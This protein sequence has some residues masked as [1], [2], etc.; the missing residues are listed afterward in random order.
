MRA[1]LLAARDPSNPHRAGGDITMWEVARHLA[2]RGDAVDYVCASFPGAAPE[3][4]REGVHIERLGGLFTAAPRAFLRYARGRRAR[5]DVVVEEALGGLRIPYV[6]SAYVGVPTV[7]FWYQT[8]RTIFE[9]QFGPRAAWGL[10]RVE[11]ML[12]RLHQDSYILTC[13]TTSRDALVGMGFRA[14]RIT[15]YYPGPS[16]GLLRAAVTPPSLPREDLMLILGKIRRYKS[17]HH[18]IEILQRVRAAVP[19]ARLVIAGRRED[20]AY[21]ERMQARAQELGLADAVRIEVDISEERKAELLEAAKALLITSPV[22]GFGLT[23]IEANLFGTP[24]V[25]SD[26]VS[27]EAVVQGQTGFRVPF[28]DLDAFA[29]TVV[30]LFTDATVFSRLS[31]SARVYAEGFRWDRAMGPILASIDQAARRQAR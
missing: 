14:D 15:V 12:A 4:T 9:H 26:G 30:T 10:D 11:R 8:H 25:A 2:A 19:T 6:A 17:Y 29:R 23:A 24:V 28:G 18:G 5:P 7:A 16:E 1:L 3:E 27:A 13:S 31:A 21:E 22:E 20:T